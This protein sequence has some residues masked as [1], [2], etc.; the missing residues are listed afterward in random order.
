[1]LPKQRD[2]SGNLVNVLLQSAATEFYQKKANTSFT[3]SSAQWTDKQL[4]ESAVDASQTQS[5]SAASDAT[6]ATAKPTKPSTNV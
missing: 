2:R 3:A 6:G 5:N 1:M 4:A